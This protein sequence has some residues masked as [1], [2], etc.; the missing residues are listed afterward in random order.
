MKKILLLTLSFMAFSDF[1]FPQGNVYLVIGSDTAIWDVMDVAKYNCTYS[2]S[3]IPDKTKNFFEVMQSS[4]RNKFSDSFGNK[5]KLTW[6][7]MCGNIFRYATNKNVPYA[8]LIVPYQSKKYYGD[9]FQLFGDE[10]TLHYHTFAWTDYDKDGKYY[11][12]QAKDFSECKDDFYY[13]L[14]QLLIEDNIFPVS[15]RSGWN[16]MDNTWQAELDKLIPYSMHNEAPAYRL[17]TTE[18]LDNNFDWRL[19]SQEFIPYRPSPQNYQLAGNGKG[20]NLHSKYVGYITQSIMNDIFTKAKTRDQVVCLWGHVWDDQFLEYVLKIDSLAKKSVALNP[21]VKFKYCTA[22]EGMQLWRKNLDVNPPLITFNELVSGD[23][24]KF[25]VDV[26]ESIFQTM[27]F[28]ALKFLDE[29]YNVVRLLPNGNNSWITGKEFDKNNIAKIGIAIT[30]TMGNLSTKI[31]NYLPDDIYVDN[32]SSAYQELSGSW[33]TESVASW[34]LDSRKSTLRSGDSSK[35]RWQFK[36]DSSRYYNIFIQVPKINSPCNNTTF[37]IYNNNKVISM[38]NLTQAIPSGDWVYISTVYLESSLNNFVEMVAA[39][40][41]Q[42]NKVLAA[43][44]VKITPLVRKKWLYLQNSSIDLGYVIKNDTIRTQIAISNQGTDNLTIGNITGKYNHVFTETN[45][46]IVISKFSSIQLPVL[47]ISNDLGKQL[48]TLFIH[49]D[50]SYKP[51]VSLPFTAD[52]QN[53]FKIVDNEEVSNYKES[54]NWSKSV[55]QAYG[56]TSRFANLN[57]SPKAYA[58]FTTRVKENALYNIS[59]IVPKTE[60]GS[61][62]ALY[63]IQQE[64]KFVDSI[65]INQNLNSGN[66]VK[67]KNRFLTNDADV[68]IKII[69]DGKATAGVVLR[70]DAIK[71]DFT[72]YVSGMYQEKSLPTEFKLFQNYPNPF[73][74]E[75]VICYQLASP[76]TS[77]SGLSTFSH[78]IL[79]VYDM[80]GR[81]VTTLV[82]EYKQAGIYNCKLIIDN[83][84]LMSNAKQGEL[85]SGV[86]FYRLSTDYFS[87][88]KKMIILK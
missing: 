30:D 78:V 64:N 37:R 2:N 62:N 22:V 15:F 5:L 36:I 75:T 14:A 74:A 54:G 42:V 65:Y 58:V 87:D 71:I 19:A 38:I 20:W 7:L 46:P 32:S 44:A 29:S 53:Y 48:D 55:A 11:W 23:K 84:R 80:L 9:A 50:D 45:F 82:D 3:V 79:K 4:Y 17:D 67:I 31:V 24:I 66:W 6:W 60:N 33:T 21:T 27:P 12:N 26:N 41:N 16:T 51:I 13:T 47:F 40:I 43:D 8:N 70:A 68:M 34:G 86:Y 39:E 56:S 28:L 18:P 63:I 83:A 1:I 72:G 61:N 76:S 59:F 25:K 81:E 57:Q 49:S 10:L 88:T 35:V 52:V 73:N 69:D 77:R 85:P